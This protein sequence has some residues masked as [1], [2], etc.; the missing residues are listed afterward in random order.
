MDIHKNDG[1]MNFG[2][3]LG[4]GLTTV[5]QK[6]EPVLRREKMTSTTVPHHLT[7]KASGTQSSRKS[8]SG[9]Q[10]RKSRSFT[11][12]RPVLIPDR[13]RT[14]SNLETKTDISGSS[15]RFGLEQIGDGEAV[16]LPKRPSLK[17]GNPTRSIA[18]KPRPFTSSSSASSM[19]DNSD[20]SSFRKVSTTTS[21]PQK[22]T[23]RRTS[24]NETDTQSIG[25][26]S[27][28]THPLHVKLAEN[29]P[30]TNGELSRT[31]YEAW[32]A[33]TEHEMGRI[34][35]SGSSPET[36]QHLIE[37]Y[38]SNNTTTGGTAAKKDSTSSF[39]SGCNNTES[40]SNV[41]K[42]ENKQ[43]TGKQKE[44]DKQSVAVP[45]LRLDKLD[46][47]PNEGPGQGNSGRSKGWGLLKK[48][49]IEVA[50]EPN[51]DSKE[52]F[53]ATNIDSPTTPESQSTA[54]YLKMLRERLR[55]CQPAD[56]IASSDVGEIE[57]RKQVVER[58]KSV[59][60]L[61]NKGSFFEAVLTAHALSK[62]GKLNTKP[63]GPSRRT[64]V[65]KMRS[66]GRLTR[67]SLPE[68]TEKMK[69][70]CSPHFQ[71]TVTLM[72]K[73]DLFAEGDEDTLLK[74]EPPD[75]LTSRY[76]Y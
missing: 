76:S 37:K 70:N 48:K 7:R 19:S 25:S 3:D 21:Y 13:R 58:R 1:E 53:E 36:R 14:I 45:K 20:Y 59:A 18:T 24:S 62:Q 16:N 72:G 33:P 11:S 29:G 23:L 40:F 9:K 6:T 8:L 32:A 55:N 49:L 67:H 5:R 31:S 2:N 46:E 50:T 39:D 56:I 28:V 43:S 26:N 44:N 65:E 12:T 57:K 42:S 15:G 74:T 66:S 4:R 73:V 10:P 54:K 41:N 38:L 52:P 47:G 63:A 51:E 22:R 64:S 61:G 71:K 69:F 60:G 30:K 68:L 34:S 35:I 17:N 75:T 27:S